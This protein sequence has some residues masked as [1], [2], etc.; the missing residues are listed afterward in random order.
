[1]TRVAMETANTEG[2]RSGMCEPTMASEADMATAS[3]L[4]LALALA[5]TL[6]VG[7]GVFTQRV[8]YAATAKSM[9][10][11]SNPSPQ[12]R[13]GRMGHTGREGKALRCLYFRVCVASY[14]LCR[15]RTWLSQ[16]SL[17]AMV[18]DDAVWYEGEGG[19]ECRIEDR[20]S[21]CVGV[22]VGVDGVPQGAGSTSCLVAQAKSLGGEKS[23]I[24]KE[25]LR[26]Q[27]ATQG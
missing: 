17:A 27:I 5:L 21:R 6:V 22:G 19:S 2:P 25:C 10:P 14:F 13:P 20:Q 9:R 12:N 4:A 11:V 23:V 7:R 18:R 1:M 15:T 24:A 16:C 26:I 8:V 3:T